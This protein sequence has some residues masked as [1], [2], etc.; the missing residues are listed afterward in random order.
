VVKDLRGNI[1]EAPPALY[2]TRTDGDAIV[3]L[4]SEARVYRRGLG[5]IHLPVGLDV[6]TPGI[7]VEVWTTGVELRSLPPQYTARQIVAQ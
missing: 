7:H 4:P 2:V 5:G 1:M 3:Y 6:L